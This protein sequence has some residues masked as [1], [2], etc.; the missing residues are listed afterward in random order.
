[1]PNTVK[2]QWARPTSKFSAWTGGRCHRD[3]TE[4]WTSRSANPVEA[5]DRCLCF[6]ST[7]ARRREAD[8][9]SKHYALSLFVA[10]NSGAVNG[11]VDATLRRNARLSRAPSTKD[12]T[13]YGEARASPKDYYR[14]HLAAHCSA[15]VYADA[16]TLLTEGANLGYGLVR[17][18]FG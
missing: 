1:M 17:G 6:S 16:T 9:Q 5:Y 8:A 15:V 3:I 4:P 14:H 10:E 11:V 7:A 18:E 2:R 12:Y 13:L